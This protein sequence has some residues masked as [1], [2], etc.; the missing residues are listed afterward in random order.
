MGGTGC[1]TPPPRNPVAVVLFQRRS[2]RLATSAEADGGVCKYRPRGGGMHIPDKQVGAGTEG[3][4]PPQAAVDTR[5]LFF[6]PHPFRNRQLQSTVRTRHEKFKPALFINDGQLPV[7]QPSVR[8]CRSR[9]AAEPSGNVRA[10]R[11]G[12]RSRWIMCF[13]S[14]KPKIATTNRNSVSAA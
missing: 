2:R 1:I 8:L 11:A 13:H 10:D 7:R 5:Q 9:Q 14:K 4:G 3:N 6:Q 12:S